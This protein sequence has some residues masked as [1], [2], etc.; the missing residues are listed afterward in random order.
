MKPELTRKL[1]GGA[2]VILGA[3]WILAVTISPISNVYLK[4]ANIQNLLFL[5]IIIVMAIPGVLAVVHGFKLFSRM[6]L[7]SLKT[8]V[9]LLSIS[10]SFILYSQLIKFF[11]NLLPDKFVELAYL[12]VSCLLAISGY[13]LIVKL[14]IQHLTNQTISKHSLLSR[15]IVMLMAW[16]LWMLLSAISLEFSPI[17]KDDAVSS[18]GQW[19]LLS[20]IAPIV[21]AYGSYRIV[22]ARMN[23]A[24]QELG[25][26]S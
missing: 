25:Q 4:G 12:F 3:C 7:S 20:L 13:I 16:Q 17:G 15:D 21:V 14:L 5:P 23:R 18:T 9:G 24:D 6:S 26:L 2:A 8:V 10:V 19:G 22:I 11:P 1:I